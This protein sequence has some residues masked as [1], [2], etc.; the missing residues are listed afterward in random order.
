M[1]TWL[2]GDAVRRIQT[3]FGL[4]IWATV[5]MRSVVGLVTDRGRFMCKRYDGGKGVSEERLR[6]MIDVKTQ[7]EQAGLCRSYLSTCAG[8]PFFRFEQA[9]ITVEPWLPGRHADFS[10][11]AERRR[12]VQATARLHRARL[13]IPFAL[14]HGATILQKLSFRLA[15]ADEV[16]ERG[17][18]LG[19]SREEWEEWRSRA[20]QVLRRLPQRQI[21]A[22]TNRDRAAGVLCHRDL[23]PHNILLA[24]GTPAQLIDFDLAG[25]DSPIYDLHQLFDHMMYRNPSGAWRQ[26]ALDAYCRIHPLS[27]EHVEALV[28]LEEYPSVLLREIGELRGA[29]TGKAKQRVAVRVRFASKLSWQRMRA[30]A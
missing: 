1:E 4:R 27:R 12:A 21:T 16:A 3:A 28:A 8:E 15:R 2:T 9:P 23:A 25:T 18:L 7:L 11:A 29:R 30:L 17:E 6:A 19:I 13:R 14:R 20:E 5:P 10:S 24:S 26:D 22:L